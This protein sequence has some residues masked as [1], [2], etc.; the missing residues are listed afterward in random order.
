MP[1]A[2][3]TSLSI[4][5]TPAAAAAVMDAV[6]LRL[7]RELARPASGSDLARRLGL[8]RQ[9]V[10]YHLRELEKAGLVRLVEERKKGNCTER[11]LQAVATSYVV[12]PEVLGAISPDPQRV[13]DRAGS[14]YLIALASQ[15]IAEV[16]VLRERAERA[17]KQLATLSL[18]TEVRFESAA[19]MS[20]FARE[21]TEALASLAAKYTSDE[22]AAPEG[23]VFKVVVGGYPAITREEEPGA[24]RP[25]V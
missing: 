8:P 3:A 13:P 15:A 12:S 5:R 23:R 6:R 10:N 24:A 4:I 11:I 19:A 17:G 16:A 14:A 21:L 22:A 9:R 2:A 7:V 18:Q 1:H 25:I 20:G